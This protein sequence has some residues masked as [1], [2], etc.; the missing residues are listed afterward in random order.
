MQNMYKTNPKR[1]KLLKTTTFTVALFVCAIMITSSIPTIATPGNTT[2]LN[3]NVKNANPAGLAP[4]N[5]N[6]VNLGVSANSNPVPFGETMWGYNAYSSGGLSEGPV[7]WDIDDPANTVVLLAPTTSGDF[8]SGGAW[9][10]GELWICCEYGSGVLWEIDPD[11]GTMTSIGGGGQGLN[12]LAYNPCTKQM[13]GIGNTDD[14]FLVDWETGITDLIGSGGFDQTIIGLAF[15]EEC[16]LYGWDAKFDGESCLYTIDI[17]TGQT[18]KI[19]S[20]G[21]TLCYAQDGDFLFGEDRLLLTAFIYNPQ[22]GGYLVEVDEDTAEST[23]IGQFQYDCEIDASMFRNSYFQ[24]ENNV[25]IK[26]IINPENGD[27]EKDIP[28]TV[29]VKNYGET[30]ENIPLNVVISKEGTYEEYN[31]TEYI[32][33]LDPGEEKEIELPTWTPDDWQSASNEIIDYKITANVILSDDHNPDNNYKEK[34]F[35]LYFGY[36]HDVG[37]IDLSGPKSGPAQT[38]P[39]SGTI[40]NFGKMMNAVSKHM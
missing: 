2:R 3:T 29:K 1:K 19:G 20:M 16:V 14:L 24:F 32:D 21:L 25:G 11:D 12:G 10:T 6:S 39:V 35:E 17:E 15:D 13:Y 5:Q 38:F 30:E 33:A 31:E 22:Y 8:M 7:Y 34:W 18:T 28:V 26:S 23:I 36:L 40:K 27:A 37:C 9:C 4:I